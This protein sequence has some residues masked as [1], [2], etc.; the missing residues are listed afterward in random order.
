M[1]MTLPADAT[2]ATVVGGM[3]SDPVLF[4]RRVLGNMRWECIVR[5][6]ICS[7]PGAPSY[8]IDEVMEEDSQGQPSGIMPYYWCDGRHQIHEFG[9]DDN[10]FPSQ[11]HMTKY[12]VQC[13]LADLLGVPR[14][15]PRA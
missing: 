15:K 11:S 12:E 10:S 4:V 5:L 7:K 13:L 9:P 8:F 2:L 1:K 14:P 3:S 6:D